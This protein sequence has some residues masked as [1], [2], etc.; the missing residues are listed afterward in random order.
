MNKICKKGAKNI[1]KNFG[2][3]FC[4]LMSTCF[5]AIGYAA[6][7]PIN[8]VLQGNAV[9]EA[10]EKVFIYD[11]KILN[12]NEQIENQTKIDYYQTLLNS[13]I[14]LEKDLN[15]QISFDVSIYNNDSQPYIYLNTS[16]DG[17]DQDFFPNKY[18][19]YEL[20][21]L[22]T[23][24]KIE[25]KSS[26]TF[27]ITFKY[28]DGITDDD[29]AKADF[30]NALNSYLGFNFVTNETEILDTAAY[31]VYSIN[32][33]IPVVINNNNNYDIRG[34]VL[35]NGVALTE[36]ITIPAGR[37]QYIINVDISTIYDSL[38]EGNINYLDFTLNYPTK[39]TYYQVS[40]FKKEKCIVDII[41]IETYIND[42]QTTNETISNTE[43]SIT[44]DNSLD[45]I[46]SKMTYKITLKNNSES[47]IYKF[48]NITEIIDS[49][50]EA[51]YSID[52]DLADGININ[53]L[54]EFSFN[55]NYDFNST[56]SDNT[57][58]QILMF[59][60]K[61]G[62]K[63]D[64]ASN[65]LITYGSPDDSNNNLYGDFAILNGTEE[66]P[67]DIGT[68]E[69]L[70]SD[71][72]GQL[73]YDENGGLLLDENN[74]IASL[75]IDQSMSVEDEYSAYFTVKGNTN[76]GGIG[77]Y[78]GFAKTIVA[79][80]DSDGK[81]LT[82]IGFY[83]NYLHVYSYHNGNSMQN[84]NYDKTV[85]GFTSFDISTYSDQV[86][87]IQV[88]AVRGSD[89]KIYINGELLR[90]FTSGSTP[91]EYTS[92]TLG[93]LRPGRNLKFVGT[94][95]DMALYN[96]ALNEEEVKANWDYAKEK[97][98]ISEN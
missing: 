40:T 41:N 56:V 30:S 53:P 58:R 48:R 89:T 97:W 47:Y 43:N 22:N 26:K 83:K 93:D 17:Y 77:T 14:I 64:G 5:F 74:A 39:D 42:T 78:N 11:V 86:M 69:E 36:E 1:I 54:E 84:T 21:G 85:I 2:L 35:Y 8:L 19:T 27:K 76:Q 60:F 70:Y 71:N 62:F 23:G 82:W 59:E 20:D 6:I 52:I 29:F 49:N 75:N 61:E 55:I 57:H 46:N 9:A 67:S 72:G 92:A 90:T 7:S 4:I 68:Y 65:N 16:P 80:S 94:I 24:D 45:N 15:A 81:Y 12:G 50:P 63:F 51:N 28:I 88:S 33:K 34:S 3:S 79:I 25:S 18:I 73:V 87:N 66:L 10:Q 44:I 31:N 91:V 37:N 32:Q 38:V 98:N 13:S 95:Y 96:K